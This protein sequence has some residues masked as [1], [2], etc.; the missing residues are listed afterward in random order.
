M[1]SN[2]GTNTTP[3]FTTPQASDE[4]A[5]ATPNKKKSLY[6]SPFRL[7]RCWLRSLTPITYYFVGSGGF[8]HWPPWLNLNGDGYIIQ[9]DRF[10][11]RL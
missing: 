7:H 11:Y 2:K 10:S 5:A 1:K 6:P 8:A 9:S 3:V 4:T